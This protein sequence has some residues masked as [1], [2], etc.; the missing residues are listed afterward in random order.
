MAKYVFL[1]IPGAAHVNPT[2][3]VVQELV[4][5]G[6]EVS[7]FLPEEYRALIEDTG[8]IF[9]PYRSEQQNGFSSEN[10]NAATIA[11]FKALWCVP[12][13]IIER[14]RLEQ[15]DVIVYGYLCLWAR[16][17]CEHVPAQRVSTRSVYASNESFPVIELL[18][19]SDWSGL[20]VG[21]YKTLEGLQEQARAQGGIP[22]DPLST[23]SSAFQHAEML[24]IVFRPRMFQPF[25]ETF[26]ERY[27]FVGPSLSSRH[28]ILNF[29]FERIDLTRPLLF[30]SLGSLFTDRPDFYKQ[31]FAAFAD[32]PWQVVL[33]IGKRVDASS[34]GKVPEHFLLTAYAPQLEILERAHLF[35]THGGTNSVVESLYF[36]V[37][38][39]LYPQQP[40]QL[41][42]AQLVVEL[43]LGMILENE[44]MSVENLRAAVEKLTADS[45]CYE[46]AQEAKQ[47]VR[48]DGGYQRAVDALIQLAVH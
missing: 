4:R 27:L 24:N 40:E 29:P 44:S 28:E 34:L 13:G 6:Q 21:G 11:F 1:N 36:G 32:L 33:S 31:C 26:D 8:A 10:P 37:P 2:L 20:A 25:V 15:P 7:Y 22:Q 23:L 39:V 16:E 17:V 30:I 18:K 35:I 9:H 5:R 14:V 48:A 47:L 41:M 19:T 43:G 45:A 12:E 3:A 46:R 38:M 42:N